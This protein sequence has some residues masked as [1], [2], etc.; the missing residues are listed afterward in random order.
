MKIEGFDLD[1]LCREADGDTGAQPGRLGK[2]IAILKDAGAEEGKDPETVAAIRS[3]KK[4]VPGTIAAAAVAVALVVASTIYTIWGA[5]HGTG[6]G[7]AP[8][9]LGSLA[10]GLAVVAIYYAVARRTFG[11]P[12][13]E[14]RDSI[15]L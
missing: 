4:L 5:V 13:Y 15:G 1:E 12:W 9:I 7:G 14:F 6:A 2:A 11:K 3:L 8:L 10:V